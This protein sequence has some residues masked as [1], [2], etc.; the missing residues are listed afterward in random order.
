MIRAGA[1]IDK[2]EKAEA[3][4][5]ESKKKQSSLLL[6]C[7]TRVYYYLTRVKYTRVLGG[8]IRYL[9]SNGTAWIWW[10]GILRAGDGLD[11]V[12]SS[13]RP[14]HDCATSEEFYL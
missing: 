1:E 7:I 12:G 6:R 10:V 5:S 9:G 8:G 4:P 11:G 13:L 14:V 3:E 2:R